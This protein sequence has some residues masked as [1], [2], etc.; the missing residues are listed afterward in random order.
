MAKV[1]QQKI[2]ELTADF[3]ELYEQRQEKDLFIIPTNGSLNA[4]NH[5]VMGRGLALDV[6]RKHPAL[7]YELGRRMLK[8]GNR[9]Y[10]FANWQ[11]IT[12]PV[13]H[14]WFENA[15]LHLIGRSC[16]QLNVQLLLGNF[17]NVYVPRVGCGNGKLKWEHVKPILEKYLDDR[18]TIV[19]NGKSNE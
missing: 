14:T 15:D 11:L 17:A 1:I 7:P 8:E 4:S 3:W 19:W 18:Y 16:Q 5:A 10:H 12:F 2:R 6:R 9:V 13:K